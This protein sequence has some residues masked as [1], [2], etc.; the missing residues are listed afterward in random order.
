MGTK[1]ICYR[2]MMHVG[3]PNKGGWLQV[4]QTSVFCSRCKLVPRVWQMSYKRHIVNSSN[5]LVL[6]AGD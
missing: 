3:V 6:M 4:I 1:F 2:L 5:K